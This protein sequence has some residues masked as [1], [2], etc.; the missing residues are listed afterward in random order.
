MDCMSGQPIILYVS[1]SA[2]KYLKNMHLSWGSKIEKLNITKDGNM[3]IDDVDGKSHKIELK[4][5]H[6]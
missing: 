2:Y 1:A 3:P 4:S 5:S 6:N